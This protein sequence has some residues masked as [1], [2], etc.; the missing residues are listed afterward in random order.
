M[1]KLQDI[2]HWSLPILSNDD[3][4]VKSQNDHYWLESEGKGKMH[5][6]SFMIKFAV[7]RGKSEKDYDG[8]IDSGKW[9]QH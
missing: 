7:W 8:V 4:I 2:F 6:N 9:Q 1:H 5:A 3:K